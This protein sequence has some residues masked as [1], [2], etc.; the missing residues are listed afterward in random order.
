MAKKRE[1]S[2]KPQPPQVPK[3]GKLVVDGTICETLPNGYFRVQ[4][5]MGPVVLAYV[6]GK[7]RI[8]YVRLL[9]GDR[10]RVELSTYDPS[11]GRI[12]YRLGKLEESGGT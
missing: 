11:R 10:V 1:K 6:S 12:I 8:H 5:D 2:E 7:M 3:E 4:L 9:R